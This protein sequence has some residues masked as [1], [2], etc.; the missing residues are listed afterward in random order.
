MAA[1]ASVALVVVDARL[2]PVPVGSQT[3]ENALYEQL[4]EGRLPL[5]AQTGVISCP[6]FSSRWVGQDFRCM[7]TD[8]HHSV[9]LEVTVLNRSGALSWQP[10][11]AAP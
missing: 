5:Q 1:A 10:L 8:A 9:P 11:Q 7:G 4:F 6:A 2:A 3:V